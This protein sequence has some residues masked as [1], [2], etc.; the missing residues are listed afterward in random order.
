M[1]RDAENATPA[2]LA[3]ANKKLE[4]VRQLAFSFI[5]PACYNVSTNV[6]TNGDREDGNSWY[7]RIETTGE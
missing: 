4:K 5:Y 2:G 1:K 6:D 3:S 7:T